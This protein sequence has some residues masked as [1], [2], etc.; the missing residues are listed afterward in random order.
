MYTVAQKEREHSIDTL[1]WRKHLF[2][3]LFF[4]LVDVCKSDYFQLAPFAADVSINKS[5]L[6]IG[7]VQIS[8]RAF[9]DLTSIILVTLRRFGRFSTSDISNVVR[10]LC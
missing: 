5:C 1:T 10:M 4:G 2:M 6:I 3:E 8:E 9:I 7:S